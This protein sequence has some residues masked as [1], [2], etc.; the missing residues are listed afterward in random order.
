MAAKDDVARMSEFKLNDR[1]LKAVGK[2][3]RRK[4]DLRLLTG[5]GRFTDDFNLPGQV[6]AAMVRSPHPHA[7]IV[8]ISGEAAL[9]MPG[10][11]A[12]YTGDDCKR[13]GLSE[14]RTIRCR[15]RSST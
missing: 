15:R 12:V 1:I 3:L 6:W 14:I 8:A 9:E 11:L 4:E 10:V 5:K 7:R 2:P 13:D